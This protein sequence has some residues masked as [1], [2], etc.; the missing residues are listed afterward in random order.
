[1]CRTILLTPG[2]FF[3]SMPRGRGI[4]EPVFFAFS[5]G[6]LLYILSAPA[7]YLTLF[8]LVSNASLFGPAAS[9]ILESASEVVESGF[10]SFL[11]TMPAYA[12]L[13]LIV[14]LL[15]ASVQHFLL[16]VVGRRSRFELTVRIA[17]F[18]IVAQALAIIPIPG[19]SMLAAEVYT[20]ALWTVGFKKVYGIGTWAALFVAVVPAILVRLLSVGLGGF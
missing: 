15:V 11:A 3:E 5:W 2:K 18:A 6:V 17:F 16:F 1:M 19:L 12:M 10:W 14:L 4:A 7:N 13:T 9:R 8:L 20:V